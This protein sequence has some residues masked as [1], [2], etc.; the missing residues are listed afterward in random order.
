MWFVHSYVYK[1]FL[2]ESLVCQIVQVF[3][4]NFVNNKIIFRMHKVFE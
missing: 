2:I 4:H 1:P 3:F